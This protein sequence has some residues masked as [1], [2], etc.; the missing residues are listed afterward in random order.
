MIYLQSSAETGRVY[1]I[2]VRHLHPII[3][4]FAHSL[5]CAFHKA[6]KEDA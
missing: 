4:C 3:L 6:D 5:K 1:A 2:Y